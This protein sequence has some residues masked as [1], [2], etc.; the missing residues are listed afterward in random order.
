MTKLTNP[1]ELGTISNRGMRKKQKGMRY[2][3]KKKDPIV[4][5]HAFDSNFE[6]NYESFI[7]TPNPSSTPAR[8]SLMARQ[9]TRHLVTPLEAPSMATVSKAPTNQ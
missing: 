3:M 2:D 8:L 1:S 4:P 6:P 5:C 9:H 7:V